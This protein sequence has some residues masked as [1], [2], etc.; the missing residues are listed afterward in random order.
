VIASAGFYQVSGICDSCG[1]PCESI[2][3][4]FGIGFYEYCGA[5]GNHQN[6]QQSSPC[7]EA[8]VVEGDAHLIR[9]AI[10]TARRD[11][12]NGKIKAGD[13]YRLTVTRHW[14]KNGPSWITVAKK[15]IESN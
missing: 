8:S 12:K 1:K 7:C 4:D 9:T 5:R 2:P 13:K 14:R 6:I 10:H 3:V 15:K 11:H